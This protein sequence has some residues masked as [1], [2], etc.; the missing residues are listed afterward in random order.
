M[1]PK[2][3]ILVTGLHRSGT[4]WV[5]RMLAYSPGTALVGKEPFNSGPRMWALGGL[6]QRDYEYVPGRSDEERVARVYRR[7]L[8]GRA[9]RLIGR[10]GSRQAL[11]L[12][13]GSKPRVIVKDPLAALSAEWLAERFGTRVVITVRHPGAFA[14]SLRRVGWDFDFNQISEQEAL[15]EGP[16]R[17]LASEIRH[18]P[19]SS[20]ARAGLVW[21]CVYTVLLSYADAHHDWVVVT[22]E[23]LSGSPESEF[24]RIYDVLG[25]HWSQRVSAAISNHTDAANPVGARSGR[26]HDLHRNSAALA[27]AWKEVLSREEKRI[28][29]RSSGELVERIYGLE[30]WE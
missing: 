4:T 13:P 30:T 29:W 20:L 25:L 14:V 16:L 24:R 15:M 3:P 18:P 19:S 17:H 7:V 1:K 27:L 6:L 11:W 5:A 10:Q 22:H 2:A 28:V 21:R 9:P 12:L 23:Q 8:E 26:V